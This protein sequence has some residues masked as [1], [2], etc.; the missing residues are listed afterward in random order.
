MNMTRTTVSLIAMCLAGLAG[1]SCEYERE[2]A[3]GPIGYESPTEYE[4]EEPATEPADP[5]GEPDFG[6]PIG[7]EEEFGVE[8]EL[9]TEDQFGDEEET[10]VPEGAE[11]PEI[12]SP[13]EQQ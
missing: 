5:I 8:Q 7:E 2:G 4:F 11:V 3:E 12:T 13:I 6:E 1:V 9:G 10:A